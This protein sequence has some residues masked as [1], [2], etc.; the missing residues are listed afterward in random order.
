MVKFEKFGCQGYSS[1]YKLT[2]VKQGIVD[3]S[4]NDGKNEITQQLL[5]TFLH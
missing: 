5:T 1:N 4:G 2:S 3:W